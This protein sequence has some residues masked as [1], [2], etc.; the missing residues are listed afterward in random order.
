[1]TNDFLINGRSE[2]GHPELD[3]TELKARILGGTSRINWRDLEIFYAKGYV[4]EVSCDL[5]L[6]EAC[7]ALTRDDKVSVEQWM[8]Q[9]LLGPPPPEKAQRW[10]DDE[11]FVW[12]AVVAPWVLVQETKGQK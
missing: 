7:I 6:I 9:R 2:L 4:I 3:G 1:L 11:Q 10:H 5:D 12:A 8:K